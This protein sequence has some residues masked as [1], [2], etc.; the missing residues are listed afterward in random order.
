MVHVVVGNQ[1]IFWT[2][3]F[4]QFQ[5]LCRIGRRIH[6]H[7]FTGLAANQDIG[8][9][10]ERPQLKF[11]DLNM[12]VF[13]HSCHNYLLDLTF[14]HQ[15]ERKRGGMINTRRSPSC[16]EIASSGQKREQTPH[17]MQA[18]STR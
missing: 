10:T 18:L 12:F 14:N 3:I 4:K 17:P 15:A 7:T 13:Y 1:D 5:Y 2:G 9:C 6:D 8:V 11:F 16:R